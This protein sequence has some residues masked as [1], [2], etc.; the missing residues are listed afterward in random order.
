MKND[1]GLL[2]SIALFRGI[3]SSEL[4]QLLSCLSMQKKHYEKGQAVFFSGEAIS[5]FG[6]VLSG[7]VQVMQDDF[8]GNR[9]ILASVGAGN[10]FGESFA[11]AELGA[12]PISVFA[13]EDSELLLINC[14]QLTTPCARSCAFHGKLI[15]NL[16][17]IVSMKNIALTQKM[18]VLSKR[19]TREKLL[20]YLSMEA[21]KAGSRRFQIPFSRQALAD[22]LSVDRSAMSAELSKLKADGVLNVHKNQ[23]ELL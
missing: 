14:R 3:E 6:I 11:Y 9:S 21:K 19:T 18:E 22:Y 17:H 15:Q 16:L 8:Y 10:L 23:F 1:F 7:Q 5:R 2:N 12:L 13:V 4:E 20:A